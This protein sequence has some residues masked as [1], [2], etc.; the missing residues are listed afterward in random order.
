[1]PELLV[2]RRQR[3]R[4]LVHLK[5]RDTAFAVVS[6]ASLSKIESFKKRMQWTFPWY[7]SIASDFNYD[8]H[9]TLDEAAGSV[10]YNFEDVAALKQAGKIWMDELPGLSVFLRNGDGV[11]HTYSTYQRGLDILI[12]T[13][14]YLDLTPLGRHEDGLQWAMECFGITTNITRDLSAVEPW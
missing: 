11:F 6:R 5:A 13:Y 1:L 2:P 12:G 7:S 3:C 9:V 10:E 14:N 4:Q 8:F